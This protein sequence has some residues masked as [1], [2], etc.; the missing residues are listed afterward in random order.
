MRQRNDPIANTDSASST[1]AT[2]GAGSRLG[3]ARLSFDFTF[4]LQR[5]GLRRGPLPELAADAERT[6]NAVAVQI[7]VRASAKR[8]ESLAVLALES[9]AETVRHCLRE[10]ELLPRG[11]LPGARRV[12]YPLR[13]GNLCRREPDRIRIRAFRRL[14]GRQRGRARRDRA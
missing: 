11:M 13:T 3:R 9:E 14:P 8:R 10:A 4:D 6:V 7:A 5:Q 2:Q 12:G 1:S